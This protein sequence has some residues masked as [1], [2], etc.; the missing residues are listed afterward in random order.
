MKDERR[1]LKIGFAPTRRVMS[2]PKAFNKEEAIRVKKEVE[3]YVKKFPDVEWINLDTTNEEGLLFN[4]SDTDAVSEH[5]IKNKV[6]AVFF[7]HCNFGSEEAVA[8]VARAVGKPVLI[9]GPRD[10]SP[11]ENGDRLRDAQ[12]GMFA[13][14]KVLQQF[15][16]KYTYISNCWITDVAFE[17]GMDTFLGAVSVVKALTHLRIGQIGV[18]PDSFWSV[19][20][21][22]RELMEK[23]G[24]EIVPVTLE[25]LDEMLKENLVNYK[26]EVLEEV[27]SLK[28]RFPKNECT[29]DVWVKTANL[30]LTIRKWCEDNRLTAVAS[31][32][33]KPM[34]T[35]AGV[36]VCFTFSE[37]TGE[38]IPVI[39][40]MDI[41]GAISSV[42]ALAAG[43]YDSATF[44]ADLTVRHPDNDNAEL[45]W[46][47]GVFPRVLSEDPDAAVGLHFNRKTAAVGQWELKHGDV[48]VVRFDG[49]N[50]EYSCLF[51]HGR[52]V[53]G[54]RT[55][56]TYLW[57][58]F[59]NWPLW[60][61]RFMEGPYIHHCVGV[62]GKLAPRIWEACKYIPALSA[63]PVKPDEQEIKEYLL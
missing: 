51:G 36:S 50:G 20:A 53:D 47:C 48:T 34:A 7:P 3:E 2:T 49:S 57:V 18:R 19:K 9:W 24:I 52:G 4:V 13:V 45:L 59:E 25:A 58:E 12:C 42:I 22:E 39:C 23:F 43:R 10:E 38:G 40:E 60:E 1:I 16:V 6:D 35:I 61:R 32:C 28:K 46:H 63:D 26:H 55:F 11:D 14:T 29:E 5:F 44:L 33:W 41:H 17:K 56:G 15:G 8:K 21:N 30:K 27:D 62:Y 54:P 37:L 31:E